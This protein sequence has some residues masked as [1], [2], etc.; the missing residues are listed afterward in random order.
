MNTGN[1]TVKRTTN[2][3]LAA[4]HTNR[5]ARVKL[6]EQAARELPVGVGRRGAGRQSTARRDV[7]TPNPW[8]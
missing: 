7:P 2:V 1:V 8:R 5:K 3:L 4:Y 6:T